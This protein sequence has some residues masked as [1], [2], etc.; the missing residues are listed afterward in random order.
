GS[1]GG[2][3]GG[4][5]C[6]P[7]V[8]G[9]LVEPQK[10][11]ILHMAAE[12]GAGAVILGIAKAA[13]RMAAAAVADNGD[14]VAASG[15][16]AAAAGAATGAAAEAAAGAEIASVLPPAIDPFAQDAEGM[17]PLA[18]AVRSGNHVCAAHLLRQFPRS[19]GGGGGGRGGRD[20][21]SK[22]L[23]IPDKLGRLPLHWA[24]LAGDLEM[25]ALLLSQPNLPLL[26]TAALKAALAAESA[27]KGGGGAP[28]PPYILT[29]GLLE[30]RDKD[31]WTAMALAAAS[32]TTSAIG[33]I[34][35]LLG[36]GADHSG[37]DVHGQ[38]PLHHAAATGNREVWTRLVAAGARIDV[39]DDGGATPVDR[40]I[41]CGH[42]GMRTNYQGGINKGFGSSTG[43]PPVTQGCAAGKRIGGGNGLSGFVRAANALK[44]KTCYGG[45][46][47]GNGRDGSNDGGGGRGISST[48]GSGHSGVSAGGRGSRG[49]AAAAVPY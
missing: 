13:S 6:V 9:S 7:G 49:S 15:G 25:A 46:S 16:E 20:D 29:A 37:A 27:A 26:Q 43:S 21:G 8:F 2:G 14:E 31:G 48:V 42:N 11:G 12:A 10:R 38:T 18:L 4:S 22:A 40:A 28:K 39:T 33:C 19:G 36:A 23:A 24:A 44:L 41:S 5:S 34:T 35:L 32:R 47:G 30:S 1:G 17:T 45:S 3:G